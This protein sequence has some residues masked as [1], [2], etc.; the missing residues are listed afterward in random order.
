MTSFS[1]TATTSSRAAGPEFDGLL[2]ANLYAGRGKLASRSRRVLQRRAACLR[3][4]QSGLAALGDQMKGVA[5]AIHVGH[6]LDVLKAAVAIFLIRAAAANSSNPAL[7]EY[8]PG[9][10]L[11]V[12]TRTILGS[13]Q[14]VVALIGAE[15]RTE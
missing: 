12:L 4:G 5:A 9:Q 11:Q 7:A 8:P 14:Q 2:I 6:G 10:L 3:D 1:A 13:V 15:F